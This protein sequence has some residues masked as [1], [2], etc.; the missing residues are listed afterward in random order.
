MAKT[1]VLGLGNP[2]LTDDGVG[3]VVVEKVKEKVRN[4]DICFLSSSLSGIGLLATISGFDRLIIADAAVGIE[5]GE[6]RRLDRDFSS[7][8][9]TCSSHGMDFFS[10]LELGRRVGYQIP[11]C[12]VI[13]GIGVSDVTTFSEKLTEDVEKAVPLAC[14]MIEKEISGSD[15][16]CM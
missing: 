15:C 11:S 7:T 14:E 1:L 3:F 6:V 13:F 16:T 9:N 2:I 12:I 10:A 8:Y 5:A 4:P